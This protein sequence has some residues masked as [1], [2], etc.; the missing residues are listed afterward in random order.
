M[1]VMSALNLWKE[2]LGRNNTFKCRLLLQSNKCVLF[3]K[4]FHTLQMYFYNG[5]VS[6]LIIVF[7]YVGNHWYLQLHTCFASK[8]LF[9]MCKSSDHQFFWV[10]SI[11]C[12]RKELH[13]YFSSELCLLLVS[14]YK[15]PS[16]IFLVSST[17]FL[18]FVFLQHFLKLQKDFSASWLLP[19]KLA[20]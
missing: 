18:L 20:W 3:E 4:P 1:C 9:G 7:K 11:L 8:F 13:L 14:F 15:N 5:E 6:L 12:Y 16:N 17:L 10:D 2:N 19:L